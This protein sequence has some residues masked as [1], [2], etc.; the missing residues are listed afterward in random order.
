MNKLVINI[1]G[2]TVTEHPLSPEE[3]E[4]IDSA[5]AAVPS[6]VTMRQIRL[7]L[8][9]AGKL[10]DVEAA[11]AMMPDAAIRQ[12]AQI[13]WEY[14]TNIERAKPLTMALA[15]AIGMTSEGLDQ[16]FREASLL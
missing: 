11:I 4:A 8:L 16:A 6:S 13:E 9:T 1:T 10:G 14:A 2:Q 15:Q 12:A 5:P 7:W 3:I